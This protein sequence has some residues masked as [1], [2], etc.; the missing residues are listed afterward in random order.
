M[1]KEKPPEEHVCYLSFTCCHF[2]ESLSPL[3]SKKNIIFS[4]QESDCTSEI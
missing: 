4:L 2:N 1:R 3:F